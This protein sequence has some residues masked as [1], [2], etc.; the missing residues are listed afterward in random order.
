MSN[1]KKAMAI[2]IVAIIMVTGATACDL[3][4]DQMQ[5][6]R[7]HI[8]VRAQAHDLCSSKSRSGARDVNNCVTGWVIAHEQGETWE[9]FLCADYVVTGESNWRNVPNS[10]GGSAYGVPQALGKVHAETRTVEWRS[11]VVMQIKWMY[12]YMRG[13][14]G[15][16][17]GAKK[18]K[19]GHGVY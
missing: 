12:N 5:A 16:F 13:R 11:N 10:A 4:P 7:S 18:F 14:Y 3:T 15:S 8:E 1:L 19:A 9:S 17:C 2:F 6:I